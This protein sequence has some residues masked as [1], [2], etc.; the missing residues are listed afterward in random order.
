[1]VMGVDAYN[2][3]KASAAAMMQPFRPKLSF[4]HLVQHRQ[5]QVSPNSS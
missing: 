3:D 4:S 2:I 5:S 1:M